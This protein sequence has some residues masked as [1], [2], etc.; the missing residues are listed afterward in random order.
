MGRECQWVPGGG[1]AMG[2]A[3]TYVDNEQV[4]SRKRGIETCA[5][6]RMRSGDD[7]GTNA[8]TS[9]WPMSSG[10]ATSDSS[11]NDARACG[12]SV[13]VE[14]SWVDV[15]RKGNDEVTVVGSPG[16]Q[17]KGGPGDL[18]KFPNATTYY[19]RET[20]RSNDI[21]IVANG[22]ELS[23][24]QAKWYTS[25]GWRSAAMSNAVAIDGDL[26]RDT[27]ERRRIGP[28]SWVQSTIPGLGT[29][30]RATVRR[31]MAW[32]GL[33]YADGGLSPARS[34]GANPSALP[35]AISG[36]SAIPT[37]SGRNVVVSGEVW[38]SHV[39]RLGQ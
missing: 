19:A 28:E 17:A 21:S 27:C 12:T 15:K 22:R 26:V 37:R 34:L 35:S 1:G 11:A 33:G 29:P 20:R 6:G 18:G 13:R 23:E 2:E 3:A 38:R 25:A 10:F 5:T 24:R 39:A 14:R 16:D 32:I 9:R 8:S 30:N 7:S 31:R 4:V 36:R